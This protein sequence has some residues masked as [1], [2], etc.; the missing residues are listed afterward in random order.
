[1][2]EIALH[3]L[4]VVENALRAGAGVIQVT[5]DEQPVEDSLRIEVEDD[6]PGLPVSAE[7]AS[8]PFFTT[9]EGKKTGLGLPLFKLRV[10]QAGGI[11][12]L[13][14]S[15]ALGGCAVRASM[16]LSNVDRPPLGDLAA[17]LASVVCTSPG[18]DLRARL[19]VGGRE[20]TASSGELARALPA[21][22]RGELG[23]ARLRKE[24][25][26]EGLSALHVS[27]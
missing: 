22:A 4:D 19:R 8:D 24:R 11:F 1:L 27:E 16:P 3:I 12:R 15:A 14:R 10:E 9:R 20:W 23:V 2:R 21:G 18:V 5:V 25:I 26:A 7:K 6:G 17:T 13:E